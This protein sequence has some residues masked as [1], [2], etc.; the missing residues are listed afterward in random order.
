MLLRH[1]VLFT[2]FSE[3]LELDILSFEIV[4]KPSVG[5][6]LVPPVVHHREVWEL[7][8]FPLP[9]GFFA[10]FFK[11]NMFLVPLISEEQKFFNGWCIRFTILKAIHEEVEE[12]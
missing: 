5:P 9:T 4:E 7:A 12:V 3:A 2:G 11:F 1:V 6:S 10:S 8:V